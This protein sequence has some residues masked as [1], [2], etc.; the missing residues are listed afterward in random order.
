M[1]SIL[2]DEALTYF[3]AAV[4]EKAH[5][6]DKHGDLEEILLTNKIL[7][8]SLKAVS[9]AIFLTEMWKTKSFG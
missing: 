2:I 7:N 8:Q 5:K 9:G 1:T 3:E 6:E 4:E